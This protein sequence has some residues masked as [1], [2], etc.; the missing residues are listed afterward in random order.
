MGEQ[1]KKPH[2]SAGLLAHVS[3]SSTTTKLMSVST[4]SNPYSRLSA[5]RRLSFY[6]AEER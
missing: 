5:F 4:S 6:P 2:I 3:V 1:A